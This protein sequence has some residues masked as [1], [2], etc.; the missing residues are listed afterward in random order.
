[1]HIFVNKSD[2]GAFDNNVDKMRGRG[3]KISAFDQSQGIITE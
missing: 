1:M 3:S 2:W